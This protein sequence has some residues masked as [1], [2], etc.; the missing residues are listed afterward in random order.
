MQSRHAP[1]DSPQQPGSEI[2]SAQ[3]QENL[4]CRVSACHQTRPTLRMKAQAYVQ[5]AAVPGQTMW[6]RSPR[7]HANMLGGRMGSKIYLKWP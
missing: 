1:K 6:K 4:S 3:A 2:F 5:F 7:P